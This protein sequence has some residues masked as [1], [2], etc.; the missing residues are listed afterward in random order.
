[1]DMLPRPLAPAVRSIA[2][3]IRSRQLARAIGGLT[4]VVGAAL[5]VLVALGSGDSGVLT[6]IL[7]WSW[8]AMAAVYFAARLQ[9]GRRDMSDSFA[10]YATLH[11]GELPS[12]FWPVAATSLLAPLTIHY[13]VY[14]AIGLAGGSI[15][16]E[17]DRWIVLAGTT[18]SIAHGAL[19]Y[20]A[21]RFAKALAIEPRA[22]RSIGAHAFRAVMIATLGACIPGAALLFIP[23]TLTFVTGLAFIPIVF[24]LA[25]RAHDRDRTDLARLEAELRRTADEATLEEARAIIFTLGEPAL[26]RIGAMRFL[27]RNYERLEIRS[28]VEDALL[29]DDVVAKEAVQTCLEL[30]HKAPVPPLAA[31]A[32][33]TKDDTPATIARLLSH[34]RGDSEALVLLSRLIVHPADDVRREAIRGLGRIGSIDDVPALQSSADRYGLEDDV[35]AAIR[36]IQDRCAKGAAGALSIADVGDEEGKLSLPSEL[37]GALSP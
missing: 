31:L 2:G 15:G 27:A 10:D 36:R 11:D 25:A 12:I 1:M 33:R 32:R 14:R 34:Y 3:E 20:S 6:K 13:L 35:I 30:R 19:V 18:T 5:V 37:S 28:I 9:N 26:R 22:D 16:G 24:A 4:G 17:F 29:A 8:F 23:P 21:H 7:L